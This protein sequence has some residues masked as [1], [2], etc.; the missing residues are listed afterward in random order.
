MSAYH[1]VMATRIGNSYK[2]TTRRTSPVPMTAGGGGGR[3]HSLFQSEFST[4]C[5]IELLFP[6]SSRFLRSSSSCLR[7]LPR[8]PVISILLSYAPKQD[9][10]NSVSVPYFDCD[11]NSHHK[12]KNLPN[13]IFSYGFQRQLSRWSSLKHYEGTSK[14]FRTGA[15]IYTAVVEARSTDRW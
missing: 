3:V 12:F 15:T 10:T 1:R 9:V 4:E 11:S 8:P 5:N 2:T 13:Q 14:I 7:L 6:V